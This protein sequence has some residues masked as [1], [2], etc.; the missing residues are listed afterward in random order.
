MNITFKSA[1]VSFT[2]MPQLSYVNETEGTTV[3]S[4]KSFF[5]ED[6]VVMWNWRYSAIAKAQ[7]C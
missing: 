6:G 4:W 1:N 5:F 3:V 2:D 7:A